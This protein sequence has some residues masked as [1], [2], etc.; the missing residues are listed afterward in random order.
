MASG[1]ETPASAKYTDQFPGHSRAAAYTICRTP[2][3]VSRCGRTT[4]H[5]T[6]SA[7]GGL[8][9]SQSRAFNAPRPTLATHLQD[10]SQ[11]LSGDSTVLR[12][13]RHDLRFEWSL[14]APQILAVAHRLRGRHQFDLVD[15]RRNGRTVGGEA[16]DEAEQ[17]IEEVDDDDLRP[18]LVRRRGGHLG[19]GLVE[20]FFGKEDR[21]H[22]LATPLVDDGVGDICRDL[23]HVGRLASLDEQRRRRVLLRCVRHELPDHLELAPGDLIS[24]ARVARLL[25]RKLEGLVEIGGEYAGA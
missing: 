14:V 8:A 4:A 17:V 25:L 5:N 12:R 23:G 1:N 22:L 3:C 16:L 20:V 24:Q 18:W 11:P 2:R 13:G 19:D 15:L 10:H 6:P 7:V 21:A 9:L